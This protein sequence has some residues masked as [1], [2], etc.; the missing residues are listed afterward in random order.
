M[1]NLA[2][3]E[4]IGLEPGNNET[5]PLGAFAPPVLTAPISLQKF[6]NALKIV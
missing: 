4:T 2:I 3:P 5:K 6:N 1:T